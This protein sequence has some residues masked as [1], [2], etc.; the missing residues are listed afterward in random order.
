[1]KRFAIRTALALIGAGVLAWAP[2]SSAGARTIY[3]DDGISELS[4]PEHW[5]V[6]ADIG[7]NATLRVSD[8]MADYHLAVYTYLPDEYEPATLEQFSENFAID[9]KERFEAGRI[10]APRKLTINGRPAVQYEVS[11]NMGEDRFLFISTTVEG[12]RA[13][14]QL[15]ATI[16]EADYPRHQ[17]A[18]NKAILSF[19]ESAKKRP[20]KERIDLVFDWPDEGESQFTMHNRKTDRKGTREMQMSGTTTVSPLGGE[21]LLVS[22]RVSDFK[23]TPGEQ[24]GAKADFV[25]NLMQQATSEIPDYVVSSEGEFVRVEN[26]RAYYKRLEQ[27]M[28]KAFPDDRQSQKKAKKLLKEI[29]PEEALLATM[30]DGWHKQVESWAGGS[31]VVGE[32]YTYDTQYQMPALGDAVFPMRVSQKLAG[33]VA[34]DEHDREKSCVKLVQTSRVAGAA[35]DQA[36]QDY[37]NRMFK[38]AAGDQ[39]PPTIAVDGVEIVKTVTLV[40][41]PQTLMPYEE[42]E[43]ETKTT[44]ISVNGQKQ[45]GK[46][47]GETVTRYRY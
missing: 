20:A 3:S 28:L 7:R 43:S 44:R 32:T 29:L 40:T 30:Q 31:Y 18:L 5:S 47:A 26:L 22:T 15:V 24:D 19:R 41:D 14:H 37:L 21:G 17:D 13:K 6:R 8:S 36:M 35:F 9:L 39:A 1:M 23:V 4:A 10:S 27:A 12:K 25:Q 42:N 16:A 11:G 38:E 46:E 33:R 34:C 45:T 2:L